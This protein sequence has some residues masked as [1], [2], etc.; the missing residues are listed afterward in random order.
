MFLADT[1]VWLKFYWRLPLPGKL[2]E[3]LKQDALALSPISVLEAATLVR[4][5]GRSR[6]GIVLRIGD[7]ANCSFQRILT[8]SGAATGSTAVRV[9]RISKTPA[10]PPRIRITISR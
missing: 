5:G 3:T 8:R 4:K 9:L 1:N 2:E 6:R 10:P 7:S